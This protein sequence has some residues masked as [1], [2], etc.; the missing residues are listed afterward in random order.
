MA[1]VLHRTTKVFLDSAN[2]PDYPESDWIINP[3]LSSVSS[4]AVK[5]WKIV[6]DSVQEMSQAEKDEVDAEDLPGLKALKMAKLDIDTRS[7]I[8][9]R[10]SLER[11]SSLQLLRGD[12]RADGKTNRFNYINQ[13][14]TWV[15]SVLYY[16]YT[17]AATIGA[18]TT[19]AQ[20][21][22]LTWN[23][24]ANSLPD[25]EVAI[26]VAMGISD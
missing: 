12:A 1:S 23:H 21:E 20:V 11:Q 8:T 2:T 18:C 26:Q 24:A 15:N 19:K 10:Y 3:D 5:Y 14:V 25:P 6:G 13:V 17:M 7:Y 22:Q 4:V 16:H 9:S